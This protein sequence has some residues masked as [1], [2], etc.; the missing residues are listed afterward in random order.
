MLSNLAWVS[1][2][3]ANLCA[4]TLFVVD[5]ILCQLLVFPTTLLYIFIIVGILWST[6]TGNYYKTTGTMAT[7]NHKIVGYWFIV[8]IVCF[9]WL[10]KY[11]KVGIV[12]VFPRITISLWCLQ[13]KYWGM[14]RQP[15]ATLFISRKQVSQVLLLSHFHHFTAE[16]CI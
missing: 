3:C 9:F 15:I 13:S 4:F 10:N 2:S 16:I 11:G 14:E 7:I 5:L 12:T 8:S 6:K 1:V